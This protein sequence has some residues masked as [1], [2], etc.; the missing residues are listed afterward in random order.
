[1]KDKQDGKSFIV[2]FMKLKNC[3]IV[4]EEVRR[5]IKLGFRSRV[6]D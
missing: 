6:M 5:R 4:M 2:Q 1:M 3:E